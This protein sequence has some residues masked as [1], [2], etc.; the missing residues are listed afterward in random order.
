MPLL[1]NLKVKN[2]LFMTFAGGVFLYLFLAWGSY[3]LIE[4]TKYYSDVIYNTHL[5]I[6]QSVWEL[7]SNLYVVR[8]TLTTMLLEEDKARLSAHQKRINE[9]TKTID[10]GIA[11]LMKNPTLKDNSVI[12]SLLSQLK[13]VWEAF[14]D[15]RDKELIPHILAGRHKEAKALAYGI[16]AQRFERFS[17][18]AEEIVRHENLHIS[19]AKTH[20]EDRVRV[21]RYFLFIIVIVGALA[22][23]LATILISREIGVRLENVAAV[24]K[25]MADGNL[26]ER[27]FVDKR[28]EIGVLAE[29]FNI[30]AD[31]L[32]SSYNNLEQKVMERTASLRLAN[33]ELER[34][35]IELEFMNDEI[36][37][38]SELKSKFLA[39]VSHELRTPLNSV[40][41]FS[42]LL[43]DQAFGSLNEKQLEYIRYIS[44]SGKHLLQLI[45]NILD[46]S[47][48][49]AGRMELMLDEFPANTLFYETINI[50]KPLADARG[51]TINIDIEDIGY[52]KAD[53]GKLKQIILN[54]LS[55]AIKFN[56]EH[57]RIDIRSA[58]AEN[59]LHTSVKDTGVGIKR[60]DIDRIWQE[61]EQVDNGMT[62]QFEGTGLGLAVTKKTCG[63]AQRQ[64]MAGK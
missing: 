48:I 26:A 15:T 59:E 52:I 2:K 45:N 30:M 31:H 50:I 24:A 5:N 20:I 4:S 61:F 60:E 38:A 14:R 35:S 58:L 55:N 16:Q 43:K 21:Y 53:K 44:T 19:T 8:N 13:T 12:V 42:E 9:F 49:E 47:K 56:R 54:I 3:Y 57:G 33:E 40:I 23:L 17:S 34:R 11:E 25:S 1:K 46:I 41:G 22:G 18:L 64:N 62:R 32:Q 37:R 63:T 10:T 36:R 27:V 51:I 7:K 28:D 29:E 39:T 6:S